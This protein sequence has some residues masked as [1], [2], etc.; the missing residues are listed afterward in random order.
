[1][2]F[3]GAA[4]NYARATT[5]RVPLPVANATRMELW[6][7]LVWVAGCV[8]CARHVYAASLHIH[9]CFLFFSMPARELNRVYSV[10]DEMNRD[11]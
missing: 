11:E 5:V 10:G 7:G 8:I 6:H 4:I 9:L 2:S 3:G 1:M